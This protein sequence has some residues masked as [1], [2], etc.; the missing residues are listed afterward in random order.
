V[1]S[2]PFSAKSWRAT[3]GILSR[4]VGAVVDP[5]V[6]LVAASASRGSGMTLT[7]TDLLTDR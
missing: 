6:D 7:I 1:A 3:S 5:S 4:V 2:Y